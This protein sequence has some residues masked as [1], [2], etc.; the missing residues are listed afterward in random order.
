MESPVEAG[1]YIVCQSNDPGVFAEKAP[2]P[3]RMSC[4]E[5]A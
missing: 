5:Y 4:R 2:E 3:T 1:L